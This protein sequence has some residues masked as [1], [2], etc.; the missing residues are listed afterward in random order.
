MKEKTQNKNTIEVDS[1]VAMLNKPLY[2]NKEM[3]KMLDCNDKTLRKYR[4]DG[5]LGY[6]RVGDKIYYTVDDICQFIKNNHFVAYQ[7]C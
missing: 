7:Y 3:M 4:N 6:V 1:I 5:Y 2:T